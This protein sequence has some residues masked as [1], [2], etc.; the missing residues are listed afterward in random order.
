MSSA[1]E[2]HTFLAE[3][4]KHEKA[5]E[6]A[7]ASECYKQVLA[8]SE[9][10]PFL[11]DLWEK[12]GFCYAKASRQAKNT[13]EF[14]ELRKSA[15]EAYRRS[16]MNMETE[17][18]LE[19][20]A[21]KA[22]R[23]ATAIF[24]GS[25]LASTPQEKRAKL[26]E[27]IK[28][29][30]DSLERYQTAADQLGYE[31][32]CNILLACFFERLCV[33]SDWKELR[34]IAQESVTYGQDAIE[35]LSKLDDKNELLATYSSASLLNWYAA[36]F[37]EQEEQARRELS[38]RSLIY[39]QKAS[40]LSK[41]VN[42]PYSIAMANWAAAFATLIFTEKVEDAMKFA[43]EMLKQGN[44]AR[45][46]YLKGVAYY[47]LAF[48]KDMKLMR[49]E[50]PEQKNAGHRSIIEC[51]ENAI[52]SLQ[53]VNQDFFIAET[54][55]FYVESYSALGSDINI[56]LEE[57]RKILRKAVE[58]GSKGL[59]HAKRSG[60]NDAL[61]STLHALSKALQF[62]S[63]LEINKDEKKKLLEEALRYRNEIVNLI[64]RTFPSND[65]L[66][67][68]NKNYEGIIKRDMAKVETDDE[69]RKAL[70]KNAAADLE[71]SVAHCKRW[72]SSRP[73]PSNIAAVAAFGDSLGGVLNELFRLTKDGKFLQKAI[74]AYEDAVKLYK[75]VALPSRA[76]ES[77]WKMAMNQDCLGQHVKAA[78]NF[79]NAVG[80]YKEAAQRIVHF[81]DFCLDH[82]AY[83]SAWSEIERAKSAHDHENFVDASKHYEKVATVLG[84]S[85]QWSHLSS[86][87]QAWSLLEE[88]EDLSRKE[89]YDKSIENFKRSADLFKEAKEAFDQEIKRI[90]NPDE[91]EKVTELCRESLRRRDYC[92]ARVNV[93]EARVADRNG[94]HAESAREYE[95]AAVM[96]E[97][98]LEK[99][100]AQKEIRQI[101]CMCRA[102]QKMKL[103]DSR[104]SPELYREASELFQKAKEFSTK[105][106]TALL[107]SGNSAYCKA[108]EH[109]TTYEATGERSDFLKAKQCLENAANCYLR[110]G[111]D[112]ASSWTSA[113][114]MLFD[115]QKS[116]ID[117]EA[118]ANPNEKMRAY[119]IAEK[120]LE[121]SANLFEKAGYTGRRDEVLK[122]L[123]NVREKHEFAL[124]LGELLAVPAE[125]SSTCIVSPPRMTV[126]EPL[127]LVKFERA[128]VQANLITRQRELVVGETLDIEIQL[129]N[130][131]KEIAFLIGIEQVIPE[132][133]DLLER[134]DKCV[135][136]DS[137]LN[138]KGRKLA[139]LETAEM[140]MTLKPR[141]KGR[142]TLSP[143]ITYMDETGE[144][145]ALE[146]EQAP[147]TVKELGI[148]GWLK[149]Q[150]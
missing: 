77:Y 120:C 82:A 22:Q 83:M 103:A 50:N 74:E 23:N 78:E 148:R 128:L 136:N 51:S 10:K 106:K 60:S 131:G 36:N 57:R 11:N 96:F 94:D 25:W 66:T 68:V 95:S 113:T 99:E 75:K 18:K 109:G 132:G 93:E 17:G 91:R 26:D 124:S 3:A 110:A 27:S 92:L 97:S 44:A 145:K 80:E 88:A 119:L 61:G 33:A 98:L 126:E 4:E 111:F 55:L 9:K 35:I 139:P 32:T 127:G 64:E 53:L 147:I 142:F 90:E 141:K 105:D 69:K 8:S 149:G 30:K 121:R 134:P 79:G 28:L 13:A 29:G 65:W 59:E 40:E 85:K 116:K 54:Y 100:A 140:K 104:V 144:H 117:A 101:A 2:P 108:L 5:F 19:G 87:F 143:K 72:V 24:I 114:E 7:E 122:T 43:E 138:F 46:N 42:S 70:L 37:S 48:V 137:G 63:N 67:G 112:N 15:V 49:E 16:A 52:E 6:W 133:F 58:A 76:A 31:K 123:K 73:V 86:N 81:A 107:A 102:W 71:E 118:E 84:F 47:V 62:Y 89:D 34:N 1:P 146:L 21:K 150:V 56:S 115:A 39:S 38:Q 45:D 129:A 125:V 12:I 130:L 41:Q 135:V 14:L 20:E